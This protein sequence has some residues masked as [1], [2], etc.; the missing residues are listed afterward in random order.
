[1][2]VTHVQNTSAS[3]SSYPSSLTLTL[4]ASVATGNTVIA[5]ICMTGGGSV[6]NIFDGNNGQWIQ[7]AYSYSANNGVEIWYARGLPHGTESVIIEFL[8]AAA[9]ASANIAEVAGAYFVDPLDTWSQNNGTSS[10]VQVQSMNPRANGDITFGVVASTVQITGSPSGFTAL[11]QNTGV[12]FAA[13]YFTQSGSVSVAPMWTTGS[14]A[15]F[16]AAGACFQAGATGLNPR[17]QFPEVLVELCDTPSWQTPFSGTGRWIN[18]SGY[19]IDMTLG[20]LGRQHELDRIQSTAATIT[21]DNRSGQF[22]TWNS[23]GSFLYS[24]GNGLDPMTPVKVTAAWQGITYPVYYGYVQEI[25]ND[26]FDV[27]NVDATIQCQDLLQMLSLKYLS[28]S[29]YAQIIEAGG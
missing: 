6:S 5:T 15:P 2:A 9:E 29:N 16:V 19:V 4:G 17:L 22:N 24:G 13:G 25:K 14:S 10:S 3:A 21:V 12:G 18:F 1:M 28:N 26:V 7:A 11:T 27:V 23:T 20:P 8:G